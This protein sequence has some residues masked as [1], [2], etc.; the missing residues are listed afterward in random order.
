ML[1]YSRHRHIK[2]LWH[3]GV[4]VQLRAVSVI[5]QNS[6]VFF[7]VAARKYNSKNFVH[8]NTIPFYLSIFILSLFIL[9]SFSL[10]AYLF[11]CFISLCNLIF[12]FLLSLSK[13]LFI[14]VSFYSPLGNISFCFLT[15]CLHSVFFC[16]SSISSF[17]LQD[18]K[19]YT[20]WRNMSYL[21]LDDR[22]FE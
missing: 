7:S 1:C 17:C 19:E 16:V 6:R 2:I 20:K 14:V 15:E 9:W 21:L 3:V 13:F 22:I 8:L 12:Y 5:F 11:M 18:D 4:C 10:L